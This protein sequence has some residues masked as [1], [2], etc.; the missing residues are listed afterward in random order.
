MSRIALKGINPSHEVIVGL[1]RPLGQ[2][3]YQVWDI[4]DDSEIPLRCSMD[5]CDP[6]QGPS[7]NAMLEIIRD[8]AAPCERR[9]AVAR[10]IGLDLDPGDY[11]LPA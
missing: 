7:Q 3:F 4:E 10:Y 9:D 1:D 11:E 8:H 6:F 2:W 5:D